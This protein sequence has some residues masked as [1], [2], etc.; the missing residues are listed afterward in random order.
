[1]A[2][3]STDPQP[4]PRPRA[5]LRDLIGSLVVLLVIVGAIVGI[6][7]G[8][9]FSPGGPSVAA[10]TRTVDVGLDLASAAR[11]V[12]FPIR[13]PSL[14]ADWRAN[15]AST[16]AV[17]RGD[18][19]IVRVGWLT[20]ARYIQLSQSGGSVNDVVIA[21]TGQAE[22][23]SSGSVDVNGTRWTTYPGRRAE[24]AWVTKLDRTT[25]L[26]TGTADEAEFR[27]MA[28]AIQT[29]NPLR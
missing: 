17:G 13:R 11:S 1:V 25:V 12:D 5:T 18:S 19:V 28:T 24:Q 2:D 21:E 26:I 6:G 23:I 16:T 10:P 9:S 3:V 20:P 15:T 8:C 27:T 7:R 29:A 14:P 22:A 4:P